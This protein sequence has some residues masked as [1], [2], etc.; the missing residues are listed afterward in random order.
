MYT[1]L[2]SPTQLLA[3][4]LSQVNQVHPNAERLWGCT[5]GST[6]RP[7]CPGGFHHLHP[8]SDGALFGHCS[9]SFSPHVIDMHGPWHP[10]TMDPH[11]H[12]AEVTISLLPP[13][14]R[15]FPLTLSTLSL[16][17][18]TGKPRP[19]I[20][21]RWNNNGLFANETGEDPS[22]LSTDAQKTC[23]ELSWNLGQGFPPPLQGAGVSEAIWI[24]AL[25]VSDHGG[26]W[27]KPAMPRQ[28]CA[29][30]PCRQEGRE[31]LV[32]QVCS[33]TQP[34]LGACLHLSSSLSKCGWKV[35]ESSG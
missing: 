6:G 25:K 33:H 26:K 3:A 10:A 31:G 18:S 11:F 2:S 16:Q 19:Q 4:S 21:Y 5:R 13:G 8:T 24:P 29:T 23:Q 27:H 20:F 32:A 1:Y 34:R 7:Y 30:S 35:P 17:L 22:P 9:W 15:W 28:R 14:T 12:R